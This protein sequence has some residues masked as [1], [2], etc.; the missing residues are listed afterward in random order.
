MLHDGKPD[1]NT[2][3]SIRFTTQSCWHLAA[4][5]RGVSGSSAKTSAYTYVLVLVD[6][7]VVS[8]QVQVRTELPISDNSDGLQEH[9]CKASLQ[10]ACSY[11]NC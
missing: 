1:S 2:C 7:L 3:T 4:R 11:I 10:L 9:E 5:P 6:H 8:F